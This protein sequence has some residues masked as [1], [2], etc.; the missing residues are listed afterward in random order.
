MEIHAGT[1]YQGVFEITDL[2]ITDDG[3]NQLCRDAGAMMT[4]DPLIAPCHP[5]WT[6]VS[7]Q[8]CCC[9]PPSLDCTAALMVPVNGKNWH[10]YGLWPARFPPTRKAPNSSLLFALCGEQI[11]ARK[12]LELGLLGNS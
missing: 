4:D 3:S 1:G 7:P 11:F 12:S 5:P 8:D 9:G 2:H 10:F 6:C